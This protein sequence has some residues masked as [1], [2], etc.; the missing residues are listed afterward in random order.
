MRWA[1]EVEGDQF[2]GLLGEF[3]VW[4]DVKDGWVVFALLNRGL[5]WEAL[6]EGQLVGNKMPR[7]LIRSKA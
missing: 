1:A 2:I 4:S 5:A 7:W 3:P 6:Q